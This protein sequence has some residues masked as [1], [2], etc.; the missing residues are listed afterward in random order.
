[1]LVHSS[2]VTHGQLTNVDLVT[3]C[4]G[5]RSLSFRS[6][7]VLRKARKFFVKLYVVEGPYKEMEFG[8]NNTETEKAF[9]NCY[10]LYIGNFQTLENFLKKLRG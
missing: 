1:M 5:K 6:F 2:L 10:V 8:V 3:R 7:V 9:R 4:S